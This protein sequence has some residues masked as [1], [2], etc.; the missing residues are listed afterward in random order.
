LTTGFIDE[1]QFGDAVQFSDRF[2]AVYAVGLGTVPAGVHDAAGTGRYFI[3][4]RP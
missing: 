3:P 2:T 1:T 4:P